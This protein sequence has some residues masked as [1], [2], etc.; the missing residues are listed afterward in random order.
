MD[1]A[2]VT[3]NML[4]MGE[5]ENILAAAAAVKIDVILLKGAA[6]LARGYIQP[7]ER[8]MSDA[9]FFVR[10]QHKKKFAGMLAS[11][12][13]TRFSGNEKAYI[14]C[15]GNDAA[16][17]FPVDIH[18]CLWHMPEP[19]AVWKEA[20]PVRV[21]KEK[22]F[23]LSDPAMVL[24]AIAHSMLNSAC[25]NQRAVGDILSIIAPR[26]GTKPFDWAELC[27]LIKELNLELMAHPALTRLKKSGADVPQGVIESSK[28]GGLKLLFLPFFNHAAASSENQRCL[29]YMLPVILHP[30]I[31]RK[32]FFPDDEFMLG[33]FGSKSFLQRI[34]RPFLLTGGFIKAVLGL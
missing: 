33:R 4:I 11:L 2:V 18:T 13:Y 7:G 21:G 12:G 34:K 22:A 27:R 19:D 14:K 30:S 29:E 17:G 24:H 10:P 31:L 23:T 5:A 16:G 8:D 9:D 32:Q 3:R 26:S 28:P 1:Y 6:M 15:E 25:L 20:R